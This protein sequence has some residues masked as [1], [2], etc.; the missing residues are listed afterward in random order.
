MSE[1]G[2]DDIRVHI[3]LIDLGG[4]GSVIREDLLQISLWYLLGVTRVVNEWLI[5]VYLSELLFL[6]WTNATLEVCV[7][8]AC[9]LAPTCVVGRAPAT[10]KW[11]CCTLASGYTHDETR[12]L[13]RVLMLWDCLLDTCNT[14]LR[15][16]SWCS[17][18]K[19]TLEGTEWHLCV[20]SQ[21]CTS[22]IV[23]VVWHLLVVN[24]IQSALRAWSTRIRNAV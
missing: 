24:R 10:S 16:F 14:A 12:G 8:L 19:W 23:N 2:V 4:L 22:S 11:I 1:R 21:M 3:S 5:E 7:L 17:D 9:G 18:I 6:H 15:D 20:V 13:V